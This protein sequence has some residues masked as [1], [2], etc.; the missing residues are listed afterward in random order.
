MN[1]R[2]S[3][4]LLTTLGG[5]GK[6][7]LGGLYPHMF[8]MPSGRTFVAGPFAV[9][10]WFMHDPG[11]SN[12]WGWTD[13]ANTARSRLYGA[14][15][16]MPGGP[17]GSTRV[18]Q[19]GG[20][21]P[22]T[23]TST[24][25]D[26][27]VRSTEVFDE[28]SPGWRAASA[29]NVGRGHHNT[30]LLPDASMVTVGGGVGIRN[31][32]PWE[33][34]PAQRQVELWNPATASWRL[35][36]AQAES[37]AYHSTA[38]LL[39]DG[40]VISAGDDVNGGTDRDTAEIYE[41]PYLHKGAR[42]VI[43]RAPASMPMGAAFEVAASGA[44]ATRAALV[45]PGATTHAN[46]MNQRVVTLPPPQARPGGRLLLQL[47]ADADAATPGYYMLFLLSDQGVPSV[48]KFIRIGAAASGELEP[49]QA[50]PP[51]GGP[52]PPP[53]GGSSSSPAAGLFTAKLAL[54]RATIL[55]RERML[56]VL[57]PITSLASGSARVELHAANR[58]YRFT[59]PV[60]S[61]DGRIRFRKR[62][63]KAQ[64]NLGMGI[65]TI[66]YRGDADTRPQ[67]VRLRAASQ[68]ARLQL[69]RPTI[70]GG[71]LRASGTVTKRA[72]GVVRVQIEYVV[73]GKTTTLQYLAPIDDGRWSL[74]QQ[75]SQSARN[76]IARRKGT[77]HSYTLFTGYYPRRIRGEMRSFQVLGPR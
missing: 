3:V 12:R 30:V 61:R 51:A 37:R 47:P 19:L 42:P 43:D 35:G 64:A 48:A 40:R 62:I 59:A 44:A 28:A 8:A 14:A 66:A 16:L 9:D 71:R 77:V 56:D 45:A 2:G 50:G 75:L 15:V 22:P 55:R 60:N 57:A 36:A 23:V 32:D 73:D 74:N 5:T 6:P 1:G 33:A 38:L 4:S 49:Y 46:D 29:M 21:A 24:T 70:T 13:A 58:R 68:Q 39:P 54:A 52:Q 65:I 10:T 53:A 7:P 17:G 25:T 67:T 76:A 20:S 72:R 26:L 31:G 41:P 34:D 27:A 63:P 18:M 11:A 69:E